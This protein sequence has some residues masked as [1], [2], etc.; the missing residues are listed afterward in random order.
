M[1][2]EKALELYNELLAKLRK[3]Y[4]DACTKKKSPISEA[5]VLNRVQPGAFGEHMMIENA[6]DGPV[7]LVIDSLRDPK[8]VAKKA[9]MA[10]R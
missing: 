3:G 10:A 1:E 8:A 2:G 7:T 9:K 4:Q 5:E 6:S